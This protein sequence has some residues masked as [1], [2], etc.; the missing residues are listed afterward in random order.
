[1]NSIR[2]VRSSSFARDDLTSASVFI[3]DC[4]S[5]LLGI[6]YTPSA[7]REVTRELFAIGVP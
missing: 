6:S 1:M 7:L 3:R 4:G 2:K 5:Q